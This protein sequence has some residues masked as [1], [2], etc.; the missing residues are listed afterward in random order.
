MACFTGL[1]VSPGNR[2]PVKFICTSRQWSGNTDDGNSKVRKTVSDGKCV[3]A[4][5][6]VY[7]YI[8][9][10]HDI[11]SSGSCSLLWLRGY[12]PPLLYSGASFTGT[13][14]HL[15]AYFSGLFVLLK[16]YW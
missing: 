10:T 4:R 3:T 15:S 7:V 5:Q 9:D 13:P 16:R 1:G 14:A 12:R 8:W 11:V 2:R 6:A